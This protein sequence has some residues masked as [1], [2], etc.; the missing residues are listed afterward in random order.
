MENLPEEKHSK[1]DALHA[2][3]LLGGFVLSIV[4]LLVYE[5]FLA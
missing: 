2:Y 4:G 3:L 5:I 1:K